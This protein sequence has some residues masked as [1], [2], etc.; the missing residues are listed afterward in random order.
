MFK[1]FWNSLIIN[2][3]VGRMTDIKEEL[4]KDPR[5]LIISTY[6]FKSHSFLPVYYKKAFGRSRNI[7]GP[8]VT[9]MQKVSNIYCAFLWSVRQPHLSNRSLIIQYRKKMIAYSSMPP[10]HNFCIERK[11]QINIV[12]ESDPTYLPTPVSL[13]SVLD[14]LSAFSIDSSCFCSCTLSPRMNFI[15]RLM[16]FQFTLTYELGEIE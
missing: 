7:T 11:Y 13:P 9:C 12:T 1:A 2:G 15:L 8:S 10:T 16:E 4:K 3:I 5:M 6:V 14:D